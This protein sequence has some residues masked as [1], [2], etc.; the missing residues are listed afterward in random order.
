MLHFLFLWFETIVF[1]SYMFQLQHELHQASWPLS[2]PQTHPGESEQK[3]ETERR[4]EE[5]RVQTQ[6][7]CGMDGGVVLSAMFLFMYNFPLLL[8]IF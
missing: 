2:P 3:P 6:S 8:L 5:F 1:V 4:A 7:E